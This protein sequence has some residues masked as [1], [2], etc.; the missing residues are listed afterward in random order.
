MNVER[1]TQRMPA[2]ASAPGTPGATRGRSTPH[3]AVFLLLARILAMGVAFAAGVATARMFPTGLRGEYAMLATIATFVSTF[4]SLGFPESV[5]YFFRRS[6]AAVPRTVTTI[7]LFNFVVA[8]LVLAAAP[9]LAPW[10]AETYL[11]EG[12]EAVAWAALAAGVCAIVQ[13]SSLAYQQAIHAFVRTGLIWLLQPTAFLFALGAIHAG[14]LGFRWVGLWFAASWALAAALAFL[15][16][17]PAMRLGSLDRAHFRDVLRFSLKSHANVAMNQLNYRLDM[18]VVAYLVPDLGQLAFYHVAASLAGLIWLLPDTYGIALYPRLAGG[19]DARERTRQVI[20]ALRLVGL[21]SLAAAAALAGIAGWGIPLLF[22][23]PYAASVRPVLVL[24]PGVVCMGATKILS[25]QL[26]AENRH[27]WSAVC[28]LA[29]VVVNVAANWVLVPRFGVVGAAGAATI[30][31]VVTSLGM[32]AATVPGWQT[33][34]EDWAAFPSRETKALLGMARGA[35]R[36]RRR[37]TS[38]DA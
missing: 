10:I 14:D 37:T 17:L 30:A 9:L 8:L 38:R 35:L 1:P 28:S 26:L 22:G 20:E 3:D 25:R 31:Y 7:A 13:R 32:V 16:L 6:E 18:F 33:A 11:P 23:E 36:R 19:A 4:A 29:G 21:V 2:E 34:R 12:G 15:P 27:Q 24:L 5:I